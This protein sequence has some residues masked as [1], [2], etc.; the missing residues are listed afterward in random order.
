[1]AAG[2]TY[3]QSRLGSSPRPPT[4]SPPVHKTRKDFVTT[5]EDELRLLKAATKAKLRAQ[6]LAHAK[7]KR[8]R[9]QERQ[10]QETAALWDS[11]LQVPQPPALP[12]IQDPTSQLLA[13][14]GRSADAARASAKNQYTATK[15][16]LGRISG[17]AQVAGATSADVYAGAMSG[18]EGAQR[19]LST[20]ISAE[21]AE[22]V[23]AQMQ[24]RVEAQQGYQ[25][26]VA[27]FQQRNAAS[28]TEIA[29]LAQRGLLGQVD[30]NNPYAVKAALEGAKEISTSL[31]ASLHL[32]GINPDDYRFD[33]L[34]ARI[35]LGE[36]KQGGV[37]QPSD[38]E[39]LRL[40]REALS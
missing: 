31:K 40:M 8:K 12:P 9:E 34:G 1:M 36:K 37:S 11:F 24:Q 3:L 28:P 5:T 23:L 32:S 13:G 6:H 26:D 20:G 35:A 27:Q 14:L 33:E 19:G 7:K 21:V 29:Q 30:L 15:N 25:N 17:D 16:S 4:T 22:F 39:V 2:G 38:A 18:I 10:R